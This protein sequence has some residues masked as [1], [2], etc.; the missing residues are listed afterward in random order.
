[1]F[2]KGSHILDL[3]GYSGT[4]VSNG[5]RFDSSTGPIAHPLLDKLETTGSKYIRRRTDYDD[6]PLMTVGVFL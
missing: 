1:L 4:L 3:V 5:S 6:R 2:Q